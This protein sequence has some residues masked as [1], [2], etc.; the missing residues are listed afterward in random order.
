MNETLWKLFKQTG[1]LRY[2]IFLKELEGSEIG[3]NRKS[4]GN[5]NK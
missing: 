1:D 4:N 5:S 2:Y 3:E